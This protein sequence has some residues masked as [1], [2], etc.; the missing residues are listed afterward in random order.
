[1][2]FASACC[3]I[4][5]L[6]AAVLCGAA[7]RAAE[8]TRQIPKPLPN[9]PGN[10]FLTGEEVTVAL[11]P[12]EGD[13]WRV[14]DY[15]GQV[16]GEGKAEDGRAALGK[17]SPG[18]Y[19]VRRVKDGAP[20]A[21]R[22][23]AGVLAPL[24]AP[25]PADSPIA[26]DVAMA[27]FYSGAQQG[28]ATNLCALAGMNWVRDRLAWPEMERE[29]GRFSPPNKYDDT[30]RIQSAAGL[31]A[32][33]VHH[34]SPGWANKDGKRFP[35]DLRDAYSFGREM[36]KRWRGQVRAFE[37]W[38][39]AD[40]TVFGGHTGAEMA[41]LQKAS[42]L[43]LK[44]GNPEV[45][46]CLNVFA[47]AQGAI[48]ADLH[49]NEAWPYFETFN[50]HHYAGTDAYPHIYGAFRA[51]SAG[52][53][54]WVT[55]CNV[56]VHWSGDKQ[57]QEPSDHDLRVQAERVATVYAASLHEGSA[58]TFYFLLPHY[59]EGQTQFG[60]LH[61][62]L[63]PR[64]AFLSVAAAGRL[65]AD[66]RP[67]GR[68]RPADNARAFVFRARPDGQDREVLVAWT[69]SGAVKVQ[70]PAPPVAVFDHLGRPRTAAGA[71]LELRTAPVFALFAP[72]TF[73]KALEAPPAPAKPLDGQPSPVVFQAVWP[74]ARVALEQ[75][76]YR[77][78]SEKVEGIPVFAYNFGT[79]KVTGKVQVKAPPGWVA[80]FP[81]QLELEPNERKELSLSVDCQAGSAA[82]TEAVR[83]E[84]DFG[85][86]GKAVLSLRLRP[87]PFKLRAGAS[88]ALPGAADAARWQ[89]LV[90]GGSTLKIAPAEGGGVLVEAALGPGDRWVYPI[91]PLAETERPGA[92]FNALCF[93]L[94]ALEG[95]ATFRVIF[96]EENGSSYVADLAVEPKA[97]V[98]IEAV[99]PMLSAV[100]GAG[101][102]KPDDNGKLD[103]DKV[104]AIKI[105]CNTK[106]ERIRFS[107]KNLRWQRA[108][109][110][111]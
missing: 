20:G 53:P 23:T 59:V 74:V 10:V 8:L 6:F 77:V 7:A 91:L 17:L 72:G 80:G 90:S 75:S 66:A 4:G 76:A 2:S 35:L 49:A 89:P 30:A 47:S 16:V 12:G 33:Q 69:A 31:N 111:K 101:W 96:D 1:M 64:P 9:H 99:A 60:V 27:W 29:R 26:I 87:E 18:Y 94:T 48:L 71:E 45:L 36:A 40:I 55:E 105:G 93:T 68:W 34:N 44:A 98:T 19:E 58:A 25:T 100:H 65:L 13:A 84:G 102:S 41:S 56:P 92:G 54:L 82:L 28:A 42:Y 95:E 22:A 39:E 32:L 103:A 107:F 81:E 79:A 21:A 83:I 97:G 86:A 85:A 51:V 63:T 104:K 24:A 110:G 11:P 108:E 52:R 57:A 38:N 109:G 50:L 46:A 73:E 106:G 62:D 37:P 14:V 5:L 43:G 78:S 67:L 15:E 61:K 3:A 88:L 70:A